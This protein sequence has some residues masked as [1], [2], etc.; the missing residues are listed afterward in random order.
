MSYERKTTDLFISDDLS[1]LFNKFK[2]KSIYADLL[3]KNRVDK[4]ILVSEPI[5]YL[6]ISKSDTS[7]ISY[8][9]QDRI[10]KICSSGSGD[11]LWSTGKRY[12]CKPGSFLNKIFKDVSGKDVELFSTL[13]KS[14][15]KSSENFE[16]KVVK[17]DKIKKYYH[18]SSYKSEYDG[19]LGA[20]CMKHDSSQ[21]FLDIYI[22]NDVELL[23]LVDDKKKLLGRALLWVTTD[24]TKVMDRV[25]TTDDSQWSNLFFDWAD[26]N[27]HIY[28]TYQNWARTIQFS[29]NSDKEFEKKLE[30]KLK[31][32][33]FKYYPYL[34]TFK[35]LDKEKSVI[36]NYL[37]DDFSNRNSQYCLSSASGEYCLFNY[38]SFDQ[39]QKMYVHTDETILIQNNN[40]ETLLTCRS[41]TN[42][43]G[44]YDCYILRTE[45]IWSDDTNSY[46]YSSSDRN[47][48]ELIE[49]IIN[50]RK[51]VISAPKRRFE[52]VEA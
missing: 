41:M 11:D 6:G 39:I 15:T 1:T 13:W 47:N 29:S 35:W 30:I 45:S 26:K 9:T 7:K 32:S 21:Y 46:I 33:N 37:P 22:E 42:W 40:G 17:G 24:G 38:L 48:H 51:S 31:H 14:F 28:K 25:Y 44:V 27:S 3:L 10:E 34:D 19:S 20:S 2:S 43:S 36:T 4:S 18:F 23:V 12:Q 50:N 16:F 5:N 8:L 49:S 52:I